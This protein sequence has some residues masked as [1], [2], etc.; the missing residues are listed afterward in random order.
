MP[1][2][3]T[4][5]PAPD[6]EPLRPS[7]P[8]RSVPALVALVLAR[9]AQAR[10]VDALRGRARVVPVR[11]CRDLVRSV[12]DGGVCAVVV[13]L[14]DAERTLTAPTVRRLRESWPLLPVIGYCADRNP[15][16]ADIIAVV[17]A[18]LTGLVVLGPPGE[19]GNPL[20]DA[21]DVLDAL[22]LAEDEVTARR[23]WA[24]LAIDV[25]E[26]ARV[27]VEHCLK[28]ARRAL[29]VD[30]V[31]C[32][33]GM[34]RKTLWGRLDRA[35]MPSPEKIINWARLLHAAQRL[36]TTDWPVA[37]VALELEYGTPGALRN[38]LFRYA[39]VTPAQVKRPGGFELVLQAFR[40][41]LRTAGEREVAGAEQ[42]HG[43]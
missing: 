1:P 29:T 35:G 33:L 15:N 34:H 25:P 3:V 4:W 36:E 14:R 41:A 19:R 7:L 18:G 8:A 32:A 16:G 11:T 24:A 39:R 31:A 22:E 10:L 30:R 38:M 42:G 9:E 5:S 20:R 40:D 13:E 23:A 17:Q 28:H 12:Q 27:V 2:S 6:R 26:P 43:A 37:R 21:L